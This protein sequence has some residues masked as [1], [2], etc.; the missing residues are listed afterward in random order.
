MFVLL[1][2]VIVFYKFIY[3]IYFNINEINKK[4]NSFYH[5]QISTRPKEKSYITL[6]IF[7]D[8][9]KCRFSIINFIS[10]FFMNYLFFYPNFL[11]DT[12]QK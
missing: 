7:H 10:F 4:N 2:K 8:L 12:M 3:F 11:F 1:I 5:N 6:I 9:I